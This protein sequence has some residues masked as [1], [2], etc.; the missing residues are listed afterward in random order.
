MTTG[1]LVAGF[2]EVDDD[3]ADGVGGCMGTSATLLESTTTYYIYITCIIYF[4]L[5]NN[6]L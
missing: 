2:E 3:E 6:Q 5:Y 4:Y 1:S